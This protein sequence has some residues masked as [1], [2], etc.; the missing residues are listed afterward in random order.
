MTLFKAVPKSKEESLFNQFLVDV[1]KNVF[2]KIHL[3][4]TRK[5]VDEA[6]VQIFNPFK[7]AIT[8]RRS[9]DIGSLKTTA[10]A[11]NLF[12]LTAS[13]SPLDLEGDIEC[14]RFFDTIPAAL[15][16][17]LQ[18]TDFVL[19]RSRKRNEA[20]TRLRFDRIYVDVAETEMS[21]LTSQMELDTEPNLSLPDYSQQ[22]IYADFETTLQWARL[23][24][25]DIVN[26]SG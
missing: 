17:T 18:Q 16:A 3:S 22:I 12:G 25:G 23:I 13:T 10:R 26:I 2:N 7:K 11:M 5:Q 8:T 21:L 15:G 1:R 4:G 24:N 19:A 6:F 14:F 9:I 20:E